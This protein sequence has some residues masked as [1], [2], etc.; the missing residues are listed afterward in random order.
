MNLILYALI[1]KGSTPIAFNVL[2]ECNGVEL[3]QI[4][5]GSCR[6]F[7]EI[8]LVSIEINLS[9]WLPF[10][11][12]TGHKSTVHCPEIIKLIIKIIVPYFIVGAIEML[13]NGNSLFSIDILKVLEIFL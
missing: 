7:Y 1:L 4:M 8:F 10:K 5:Y 12:L 11:L 6:L 3:I 13:F 9:E 2:I